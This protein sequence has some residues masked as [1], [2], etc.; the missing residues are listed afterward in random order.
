MADTRANLTISASLLSRRRSSDP[1][2]IVTVVD[3]TALS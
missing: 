1:V 2:V 3:H